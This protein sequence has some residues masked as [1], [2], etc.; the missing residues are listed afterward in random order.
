[1][2][3]SEIYEYYIFTHIHLGMDERH[4]FQDSLKVRSY[5][6]AECG[7]EIVARC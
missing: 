4:L 3:Q 2:C 6:G 5:Y 7:K 1:V